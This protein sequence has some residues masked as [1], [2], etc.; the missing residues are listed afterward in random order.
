MSMSACALI[1]TPPVYDARRP[2]L[3]AKPNF[4]PC[5]LEDNVHTECVELVRRDYD[6]LIRNLTGCCIATGRSEK[7]CTR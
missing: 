3:T 2:V 4:Y 6:V 5:V 1:K 7:Y